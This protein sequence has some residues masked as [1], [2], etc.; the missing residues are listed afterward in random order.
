M[1]VRDARMGGAVM[2]QY[3]CH[4]DL[5]YDPRAIA[6]YGD[7]PVPVVRLDA[8]KEVVEGLKY[9]EAMLCDRKLCGHFTPEEIRQETQRLLALLEHKP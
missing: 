7:Q 1:L 5:E 4:T 8:L 9:I 3:C 2:I 6:V